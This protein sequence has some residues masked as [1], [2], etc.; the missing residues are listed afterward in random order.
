[1]ADK[2]LKDNLKFERECESQGL[3]KIFGVDEVGAGPLAGPLVVACVCMPLDKENLIPGID[4]SKKLTEKKREALYEEILK[5]AKAIQIE[6]ISEKTIDEINIYEA[7][8]LGMENSIKNLEKRGVMPHIVL[9]DGTI[10][11]KTNTKTKAIVKGDEQSYSIA[12]ASIVA[13]VTRDRLMK[14]LSLR[15]KE[16]GFEQHKGYGTPNHIKALKE[17]GPCELHRKSFISKILEAGK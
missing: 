3:C 8:R 17:Y 7:R 12:A 1:M 5:K 16:Y 11:L 9:V 14:E 4:D 13:K 6:H 10:K 15:H 2:K